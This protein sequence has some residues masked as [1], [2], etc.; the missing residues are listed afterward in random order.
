ML[1]DEGKLKWNMPV[2]EYLPDFKPCDDY[3]T[4]HLTPPLTSPGP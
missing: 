4:L 3:A 2:V 1:I